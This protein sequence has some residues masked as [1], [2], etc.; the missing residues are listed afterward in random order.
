MTAPAPTLDQLLRLAQERGWRLFPARRRSKKPLISSWPELASCDPGVIRRWIREHPHSNWAVA[1]GLESNGWTLDVDGPAGRASLAALELQHGPL[2]L[3]LTA[4]TGRADGGEQRWFK[5]PRCFGIRSTSGELGA[6]LDIRGDGGCVLVPPSVH[7]SGKLYEWVDD[8]LCIAEAPEWLLQLLAGNGKEKGKANAR[9]TPAERSI[10]PLHQRNDG[11]TRYGG[12]LRRKGAD[13]PELVEKLL[14]ANQR[15]CQPPLGEKEVRRIAASVV[16]Y[17]VGGPDPLVRAWQQAER[18]IYQSQDE[19][20]LGLCLCLQQARPDQEIALPLKRIGDLMGVHWVSVGRYRRDAVQR[21]ILTPTAHYVAGKR[22]GRYTVNQPPE[23]KKPKGPTACG[24]SGSVLTRG[25][26]TSGLVNTGVQPLVNISRP[27]VQFPPSE[28]RPPS[29]HGPRV[30]GPQSA[31]TPSTNGHV[32]PSGAVF[33]EAG[34]QG[35]VNGRLAAGPH[36]GA[37]SDDDALIAKARARGE[38]HGF[39]GIFLSNFIERELELMRKWAAKR[40]AKVS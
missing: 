25:Y 28:H 35:G 9:Q 19:K 18:K 37:L 6:G 34:A 7:P 29:D 38:M 24:P 17:P 1:T 8:T 23:I 40:D 10:L 36:S 20:F 14:E 33:P 13:H 3:T 22:A 30:N 31:R 39:A 21:G 16:R 5:Y 27:S 32:P 26:I 11:L 12:A 2:P 4:I 15:R